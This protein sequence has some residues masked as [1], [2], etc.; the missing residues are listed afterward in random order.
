VKGSVTRSH[1]NGD[2]VS[3]GDASL[4]S[5][6]PVGIVEGLHESRLKLRK[7]WLEK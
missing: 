4:E 1:V 2:K 6:R 5:N 7:E 3:Q